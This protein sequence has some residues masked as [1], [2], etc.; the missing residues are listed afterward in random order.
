LLDLQNR[1]AATVVDV[2]FQ[3]SV[4]GH[5]VVAETVELKFESEDFLTFA[6]SGENHEN[7]KEVYDD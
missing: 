2:D 3:S 6:T 7:W 5:L 4:V 1:S